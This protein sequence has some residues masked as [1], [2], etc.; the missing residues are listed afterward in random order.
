MKK[1]IILIGSLLLALTSC[2]KSQLD[3]LEGTFP[4]PTKV[5][6]TSATATAELLDAYHLF[7]LDLN[8]GSNSFHLVMAGEKYYLPSNTYTPAEEAA[9]KKGNFIIGKTTVNGTAVA[10]GKIVVVQVPVTE[11]D[12][13]Y[14]I[15]AVLFLEDGNPYTLT[16]AGSLSFYPDPI[17]GDIVV[18]NTLVEEVSTTEAGT[19]K[20]AVTVLDADEAIAAYFEL[21]APAGEESMA[22][23]YTCIEY[24]ENDP[25][26]WVVSNGW[27]FPDWGIS[28]G[29]Y[30]VKDG[31]H[32]DIQPGSVVRVAALSSTSYAFSIDDTELV[33]AG[34]AGEAIVVSGVLSLESS[35]TE[36]G[37]N[38]HV[39]TI[40]DEEN[41]T[42]A[43]FE[44]YTP[45]NA[46]SFTGSFLCIEYAENNP[47]GY[48][49]SNGWSFPD[50][51]IAG[52]SH[53]TIAG[54]QTDLPVNAVVTVV[55]IGEN[56]YS[57]AV[58]D[59]YSVL[60]KLQ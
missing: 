55:N 58:A 19:V 54:V 25:N 33:I 35:A 26:G 11:T 52:G 34:T 12:N 47:D 2:Y 43:Y 39:A 49:V 24:A 51:G 20:H 1:N 21:Y 3:P 46:A 48:V 23:S 22:G 30:Y 56:M 10:S 8:D 40:V 41:E 60:V 13:V 16:W 53:Y 14:T 6:A 50:W 38:K 59:D 37:T 42:S 9:A 36:V 29:S 17:L 28:G 44:L 27:S 57:F 4:A 15:D 7:T 31:T 18:E 5:E 45:G 32:V